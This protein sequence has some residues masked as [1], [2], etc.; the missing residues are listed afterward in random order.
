MITFLSPRRRLAS[1]SNLYET[2]TEC[3]A[4]KSNA[5]FAY[6]CELCVEDA[7]NC[8]VYGNVNF[9]QILFFAL[10]ALRHVRNRA[11]IQRFVDAVRT[12]LSG[13]C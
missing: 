11:A 6:I 8:A 5:L 13:L 3:T 7:S 10:F 2:Y 4:C 1:D 9:R 12:G